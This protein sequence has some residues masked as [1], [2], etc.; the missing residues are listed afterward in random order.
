VARTPLRDE[1]PSWVGRYRL[2]ARLGAGG[3]GVVYLGLTED[4]YPVAVKVLRPELGDD[5]EFRARFRREAA[6]LSRVQGVCTVRV[7]EADTDSPRPFLATEYAD[8]PSLAEHVRT[9]GELRAGLLYGLAT[10]LAEALTAIHGAGV[11]HRDLK[12]ANVLLTSAG[13]KVIDFGIAQTADATVLTKTGVTVG[14]PAFMAPEQII[15]KAGT[16]AD[17]FSWALTVAFAASGQSPFGTGPTDV[18]MFR[19]LHGHPDI[20][21]VPAELRGLVAAALAKNP[22]ERPSAWDLLGE[23]THVGRESAD[24]DADADATTQ[25]V[26]KRTWMLAGSASAGSASVG[27]APTGLTTVGSAQTGLA[28]TGLAP[29]GLAPAEPVPAE[30]GY[31]RGRRGRRAAV[32]TTAAVVVA[33]L[34]GAGAAR[35]LDGHGHSGATPTAYLAGLGYTERAGSPRWVASA[36]LNVIVAARTSSVDGLRRAFFF[37]DGKFAGTDSAQGSM[38][39][40]ARRLGANEI[41]LSY[42]LYKG[43]EPMAKSDDVRFYWN[44]D[45]VVPLTPVPPFPLRD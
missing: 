31:A 2:T 30:S 18:I 16:A 11:I 42:G 3:M 32:I 8:G 44:G 45:H 27:S 29:T 41:V 14:S 21:A 9:T 12:P 17:V 33:G 37:H 1:D 36:P 15:G 4:G 34:A 20:S 25:A 43:G 38:A 13:P 22:D 24:A 39:L 35:A 19:I 7:I 23:L 10:G 6:L 26:L 28:P 40:S 5:P